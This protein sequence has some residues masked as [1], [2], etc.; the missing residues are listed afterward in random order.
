MNLCLDFKALIV[1]AALAASETSLAY[2]TGKDEN[3]SKTERSTKAQ[4]PQSIGPA[5]GTPFEE[6]VPRRNGSA[7]PQP[8]VDEVERWAADHVYF[9]TSS[10]LVGEANGKGNVAIATIPF[11]KSDYAPCP[12]DRFRMDPT[13]PGCTALYALSALTDK[14]PTALHEAYF[15][16]AAHCVKSLLGI[17]DNA[18]YKPKSL[19]LLGK[20]RHAKTSTGLQEISKDHILDVE[21]IG[22]VAGMDLV[23][24][25]VSGPVKEL[26]TNLY[27][28]DKLY[29]SRSQAT[30]AL[31]LS[32]PFGMPLK[33]SI[34][35][36]ILPPGEL[37]WG[38][39]AAYTAPGDSGAPLIVI[40]NDKVLLMGI[41]ISSPDDFS[42][43]ER[44]DQRYAPDRTTKLSIPMG[45][46]RSYFTIR[47]APTAYF[48]SA[49]AIREALNRMAY[50][51]M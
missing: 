6:K 23:L 18:Q 20:Y 35:N 13:M 34:G 14:S 29:L 3:V 27:Q 45:S 7:F 25:K 48:I 19:K 12:E 26:S 39:F 42:I 10:L 30:E 2:E 24:L 21:D 17:A 32:H 1:A 22:F 41:V 4:A 47:R 11:E 49:T 31:M 38:L 15:V 36:A 8:T 40:Q 9:L 44:L 43:E 16:T 50:S 5:S 28:K 37:T 46:C 33:F 51:A